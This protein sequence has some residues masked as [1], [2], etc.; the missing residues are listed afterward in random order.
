MCASTGSTPHIGRPSSVSR[1]VQQAAALGEDRA[2]ERRDLALRS[3]VVRG[4]L[5]AEDLGEAAGE[6]QR[7]GLR[8]RSSVQRVE[9]DAARRPRPRSSSRFSS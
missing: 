8:Q 1:E 7:V 5:R 3:G 2:V 4:E 6:D 9:L